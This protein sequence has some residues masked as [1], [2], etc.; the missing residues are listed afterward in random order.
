MAHPARPSVISG[1]TTAPVWLRVVVGGW[2]AAAAALMPAWLAADRLLAPAL[3]RLPEALERMPRGEL[4]LIVRGALDHQRGVLAALAAGGIVA[5]AG[6]S[7]LWRAGVGAWSVWRRGRPVRL[8]ALLGLGLIGWWR[9][10]AVL[11]IGWAVGAVALAAVALALSAAVL[12]AWT[13]GA[14]QLLVVI[15]AAGAVAGLAVVGLCRAAIL[16]GAWRVVRPDRPGV[17]RSWLEGLVLVMRRPL[18]AAAALAVW[19]TLAAA[20]MVLGGGLLVWSPGLADR[21]WGLVVIAA[22]ALVRAFSRVAL[23]LSFA[24]L[25][26]LEPAPPAPEP[27]PPETAA[28]RRAWGL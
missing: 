2:A 4:V 10:A 8:T 3:G 14:E 6:W 27:A 18:A 5:L 7:V 23:Y 20:A 25:A 12:W 1:L 24:P 13:R 11:A 15:L 19:D 17:V 26:E 21:S 28:G 22:A 16:A 9:M